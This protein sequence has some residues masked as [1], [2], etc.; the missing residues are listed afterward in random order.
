MLCPQER[1]TR[2]THGGDKDDKHCDD[3]EPYRQEVFFNAC[4]KNSQG[5]NICAA[6]LEN[7]RESVSENVRVGVVGACHRVIER[8]ERVLRRSLWDYYQRPSA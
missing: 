1:V 8:F 6:T 3:D 7:D 5:D 4:R 2:T